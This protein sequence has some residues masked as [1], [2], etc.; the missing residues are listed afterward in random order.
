MPLRPP[1]R[2]WQPRR[3]RLASTSLPSRRLTDRSVRFTSTTGLTR[4]QKLAG[5]TGPIG[6]CT[7]NRVDG[8]G[9][10]LLAPEDQ[11]VVSL[12]SG[13]DAVLSKPAAIGGQCDGNVNVFVRGRRSRRQVLGPCR[14]VPR[15]VMPSL[16]DGGGEGAI[17]WQAGQ[18][19]VALG[20]PRSGWGLSTRLV[21]GHWLLC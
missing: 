18:D 17:S 13:G 14:P 4:I 8:V 5:Q 3:G 15:L 9:S 2:R 1:P 12:A 16:L 6:A 11:I 21:L 20:L 10:K 7:F 19:C